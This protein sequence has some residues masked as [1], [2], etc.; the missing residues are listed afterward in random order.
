MGVDGTII[1]NGDSAF[2]GVYKRDSLVS[3]NKGSTQVD[4]GKKEA[5]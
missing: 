3:T 1:T 4:L 5:L 2:E